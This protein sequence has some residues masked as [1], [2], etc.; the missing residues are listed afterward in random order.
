M[1]D[2]ALRRALGQGA[3][4]LRQT[5]AMFTTSATEEAT[6]PTA[7]TPATDIKPFTDLPGPKGWPILGSFP[8]YFKKE[9]Q[10]QMHELM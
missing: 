6:A 9:N 7:S 2:I 10:G 8:D 4:V 5:R 3:R 1:S